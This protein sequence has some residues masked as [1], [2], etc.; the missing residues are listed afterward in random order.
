MITMAAK[1]KP[2]R[3]KGLT[4]PRR[5]ISAFKGTEEFAEWIDRLVSHCKA[6]TG[7]SNISASSLIERALKRLA[8]EEGFEEEAPPR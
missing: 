6:S 3:K 7:W 4:P 2:G 8:E 5:M 1:K